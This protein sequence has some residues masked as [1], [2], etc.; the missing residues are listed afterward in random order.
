MATRKL[1]G[2]A[3]AKNSKRGSPQLSVCTLLLQE[4]LGRDALAEKLSDLTSAQ[5]SSALN[6]SKGQGRIAWIEKDQVY[7]LTTAGKEWVG[8]AGGEP[9]PKRRKAGTKKA[10]TRKAKKP[11]VQ[12]D[13]SPPEQESESTFRCAVMSDGSFFISRDETAIELTPQEHAHMLRYLE[14]MAEA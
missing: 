11:A 4:D 12:V 2:A 3:R 9:A 1:N 7:R 6:N 14:R 13:T 5:I 10:H 8:G